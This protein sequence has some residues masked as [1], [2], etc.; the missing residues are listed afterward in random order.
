[1]WAEPL[2]SDVIELDRHHFLAV[3]F[4]ADD[5]RP[6]AEVRCAVNV[7]ARS[8]AYGEMIITR[9]DGAPRQVLRALVLLTRAALAHAQELGITHVQTEVPDRLLDFARKMSGEPGA[10]ITDGKTIIAGDLAGIRTAALD[11]SDGDGNLRA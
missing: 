3:V 10:R 2:T 1:M 4:A 8:G 6:V 11:R 7:A 5:K 9:K